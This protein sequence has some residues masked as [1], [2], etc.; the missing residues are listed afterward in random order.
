MPN[1]VRRIAFVLAVSSMVPVSG[2]RAQMK[3]ELGATIGFYSPLGS[4]NPA[5][6]YWERLPRDPSDLS[7]T[8]FGGELRWWV[9]PRFGI[10]LAGS[11]VASTIAGGSTYYDY[12]PSTPT[13]VSTGSAQLLFRVTGDNSRARAWV[14]AG[15]GLVQH[16]GFAYNQL[17]K[18]VNFAGVFGLGSA[19]RIVGGLSA[20]VGVTSMIYD[21]DVRGTPQNNVQLSERG[22]QFDMFLRTGLSYAIH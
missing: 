18:P 20:D 5:R 1:S 9:A 3:V 4:F 14:S 21:L 15:G 13:R 16:D 7:G 2:A 17:G 6:A 12:T 8:E 19:V 22:R 10:A 11:T